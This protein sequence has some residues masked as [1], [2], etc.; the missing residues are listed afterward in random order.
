M[1]LTQLQEKAI[2]KARENLQG[3]VWYKGICLDGL[4]TDQEIMD[5]FEGSVMMI[6]LETA[7]W[8]DPDFLRG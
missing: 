5:D 4:P 3:N 7:Q 6:E 2:N 1:P 8:D